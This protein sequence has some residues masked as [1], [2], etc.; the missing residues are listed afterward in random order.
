MKKSTLSIFTCAILLASCS[1]AKKED[2]SGSQGSPKVEEK[3]ATA[4]SIEAKEEELL[5]EGSEIE[6][7]LLPEGS[8]VE[9]DTRYDNLST[10]TTASDC[11]ITGCF[12]DMDIEYLTVDFVT[13]ELVEDSKNTDSEIYDVV[14]DNPK[15]RTFY[16]NTEYLDCAHSESKS[17][18]DLIKAS[19]DNPKTVFTLQTEAGVITELYI[20]VCSG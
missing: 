2:E 15:L 12:I 6:E 13:Y 16:V 5:P 17:L 8:A 10:E 11:Y 3:K 14:N 4:E 1:E 9:G 7:D 19:K 20:D 18:A